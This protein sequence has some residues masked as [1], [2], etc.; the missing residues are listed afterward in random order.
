LSPQ[1]PHYS[2][3]EQQKIDTEY[4]QV[5]ITP[6]KFKDGTNLYSQKDC[7][8]CTSELT[9]NMMVKEVKCGHLFHEECLKGWLGH[10]IQQ[11]ISPVCPRC[12]IPITA[13]TKSS[14]EEEQKTPN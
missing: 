13:F 10:N 7:S 2:S 4:Q 8:I 12:S 6:V 14:S 11:H 1:Q 5:S 3:E 9:E